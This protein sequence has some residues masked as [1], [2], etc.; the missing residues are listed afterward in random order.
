MDGMIFIG[1]LVGVLALP[2]GYFIGRIFDVYWRCKQM[3]RWLRK[4]YVV[5]NLINK[6][7]R[8]ISARV[9]DASNDI[10]TDGTKMWV[11]VK[12]RVFIKGKATSGWNIENKMVRWEEGCPVLYVNE[13]GILPLSFFQEEENVK[14]QEVG[15]TFL[16]FIF[17]EINKGLTAT[18]SIQTYLI[19]CMLLALVAAG[20]SFL[21]MDK[22]TAMEKSINTIQ[23][24]LTG[25]TIVPTGGSMQNG[26]LVITTGR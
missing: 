19:I 9:K 14:P 23:L 17:N 21:N 22:L 8:T 12:N 11:V 6:D 2:V 7:G 16:A 4:N 5:L 15:S 24:Q 18:K 3:R 1:A 10:I 13:D 20:L 26:S 25:K